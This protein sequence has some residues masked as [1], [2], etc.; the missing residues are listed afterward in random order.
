MNL[1][2]R[3]FLKGMFA[4]ATSTAVGPIVRQ[5][6]DDGYVS[7]PFILYID[8]ITTMYMPPGTYKISNSILPGVGKTILLG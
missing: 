6:V 2:R 8:D 3:E 7:N 5:L 1:T 4:V